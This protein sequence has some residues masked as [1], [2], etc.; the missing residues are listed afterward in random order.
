VPDAVEHLAAS[1]DDGYGNSLV[2]WT[3]A[4]G[5]KCA[6]DR[7]S[8]EADKRV[9]AENQFTAGVTDIA[10]TRGPQLHHLERRSL[11]LGSE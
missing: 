7:F 8:S 9:A 3:R 4:G 5:L 6:A 11:L 2:C 10:V 1:G